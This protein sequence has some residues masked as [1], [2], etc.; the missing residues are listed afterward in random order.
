VQGR[1]NAR[2]LCR[3]YNASTE[4]EPELRLHILQE[5]LGTVS[6]DVYIEPNFKCDYGYNVH[7]G[8]NFYANFD[9]IILDVC[10]VKIGDH[11]LIGPRV[12]ILTATHPID[13]D[14]RRSGQELGKPIAIGNNVW[15]G[16]GAIINPGIT[17]GDNVVVASGAVVTKDVADGYIVGGVPAKI[18]RHCTEDPRES[19]SP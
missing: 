6:E 13:P 9:L 1:A 11:C 15:V 12:S 3:R 8:N 5:L 10:E 19:Q 18:I 2:Q 7:L 4:D 14:L 17:I 16:G